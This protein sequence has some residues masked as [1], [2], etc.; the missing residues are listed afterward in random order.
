VS[1]PYYTRPLA[2]LSLRD[3]VRADLAATYDGLANARDAHA[4]EARALGYPDVEAVFLRAT[5]ILHGLAT[6]ER[7]AVGT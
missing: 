2:S 5:E 1:A 7:K 6:D 4:R 3:Q